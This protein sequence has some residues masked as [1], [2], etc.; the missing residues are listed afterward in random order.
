[1]NIEEDF[2]LTSPMTLS[3]E[4]ALK[5]RELMMKSVEKILAINKPSSSEELRILNIDWLKI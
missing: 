4:D 3:R 2:A 5:V 1:M